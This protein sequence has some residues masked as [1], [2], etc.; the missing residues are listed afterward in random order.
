MLHKRIAALPHLKVAQQKGLAIHAERIVINEGGV[1]QVGQRSD[2][3]MQHFSINFLG[4]RHEEAGLLVREGGQWLMHSQSAAGNTQVEINNQLLQQ[5]RR[6]P[7]MDELFW[8]KGTL[9]VLAAGHQVNLQ[10]TKNVD[11]YEL[12]AKRILGEPFEKQEGVIPQVGRLSHPIK[13]RTEGTARIR[14]E[15]EARRIQLAGVAFEGSNQPQTKAY[16]FTIH[17]LGEGE[18]W[19]RNC[20]FAHMTN[21]AL[22]L[23]KTDHLE[24]TGNVFYN[25]RKSAIEC[26]PSGIGEGNVFNNNLIVQCDLDGSE[27]MGAMQFYHPAQ[28]VSHNS[29]LATRNGSAF[30]FDL[31]KGYEKFKWNIDG[32]TV[33]FEHNSAHGFS[34]TNLSLANKQFPAFRFADFA[35]DAFWR[36]ANNTFTGFPI[37][38]H[39]LTNQLIMDG[40][41]VHDCGVALIPGGAA[42]R[43]GTL[44]FD[45]R[46]FDLSHAIHREPVAIHADGNYT[47]NAPKVEQ[48]TIKGYPIHFLMEGPIDEAHYFAN[49]QLDQPATFDFQSFDGRQLL[50]F[51]N[52]NLGYQPKPNEHMMHASHHAHTTAAS[53]TPEAASSHA[54]QEPQ[55]AIHEMENIH[56]HDHEKVKDDQWFV[57]PPNAALVAANCERPAHLGGYVCPTAAFGELIVSTGLGL[58]DPIH[59]HYRKFEGLSIRIKGGQW[60]PI[61]TQATNR[62]NVLLPVGEQYELRWS[63]QTDIQ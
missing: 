22:Q 20:S 41:Y 36:L 19:I 17:G 56:Q 57:L 47:H 60:A 27:S 10:S 2:P 63:N 26:S 58:D 34:R 25:I 54:H 43:N 21:G 51:K 53:G 8:P 6:L 13:I 15:G 16:F 3:F 30:R 37:G 50:H 33:R 14:I 59:E 11:Q 12:R 62:T 45:G 46:W 4:S 48:L 5:D 44:S 42:V 1:L 52:T 39:C 31:P 28:Q 23:D 18:N 38:V 35:H 40:L 61:S 29:V 55:S 49:L 9:F 7:I 24:I 32:E